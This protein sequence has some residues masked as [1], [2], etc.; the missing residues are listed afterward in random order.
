MTKP[1]ARPS[2]HGA[3]SDFESVLQIVK[4]LDGAIINHLVWAKKLHHALVCEEPPEP[5]D[6]DEDAHTR[7]K[8][9][10]WYHAE[11]KYPELEE[12]P[13]FK[14]IGTLHKSMHDAARSL[15]D[16]KRHGR[17]IAPHDYDHFMDRT[18]ALKAQIRY[19]QNSLMRDVCS[20]DQLTGAWNRLWMNSKLEREY[21]R[22]VRTGDSCYLCMADIDHFKSINDAYGH[23][24]GDE[25]LRTTVRLF[26]AQLRKY[27]TIFRY[28]GEEFLICM[29]HS[30]ADRVESV[31]N[32]LRVKLEE[33]RVALPGGDK[34][35][36]TASFGVAPLRR[37]MTI[38]DAVESA[39]QALFVAKA[40]G[41]NRV[42]MFGA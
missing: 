40:S 18:I 13:G 10:R 42:Y 7:C 3:A 22:M 5:N 2:I 21:E 23:N 25:V 37:E 41:R 31:L 15:L 32:R 14:K 27:D 17:P 20:V 26:A 34:V 11:H 16:K 29:P 33:T 30:Q 24:A 6:L 38:L 8:L 19:L 35:S 39:D 9:G 4:D 28:G 36:V 1:Q 12:F